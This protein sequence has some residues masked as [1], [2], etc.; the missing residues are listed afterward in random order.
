MNADQFL[1]AF[2]AASAPNRVQ[3]VQAVLKN[4]TDTRIHNLLSNLNYND[5]SKRNA[6][7]PDSIHYAA[8]MLRSFI[9]LKL[10]WT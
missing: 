9:G 5:V 8:A 6:H 7:S 10:V 3:M 1:A 4:T 2:V